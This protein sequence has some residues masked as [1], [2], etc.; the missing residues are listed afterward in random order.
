MNKDSLHGQNFHDLIKREVD[1]AASKAQ[2]KHRE[3]YPGEE[4]SVIAIWD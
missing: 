1:K 4:G 2:L 3:L